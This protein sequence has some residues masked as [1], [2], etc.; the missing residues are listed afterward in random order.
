M[1]FSKYIFCVVLLIS[2]FSGGCQR[3]AINGDLDGEWEVM[4]VDPKPPYTSENT[5]YFYNF[6]HHVCQLTVYGGVFTS[7]NLSYHDN[8]MGLDLPYIKTPEQKLRL[9]QYGIYT[10]PVSFNVY[11]E[12]K[13]RLILS[14]EDVTIT[15]RKF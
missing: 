10:N 3:L 2:L 1:T 15:L 13:D 4:E 12:K 5:R 9:K 14:N 7:G 6:S 8:T 11:F